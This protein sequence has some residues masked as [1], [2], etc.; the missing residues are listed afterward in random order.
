MVYH[1]NL[2]IYSNLIY[3]IYFCY[4]S[5]KIIKFLV[6]LSHPNTILSFFIVILHLGEIISSKEA[7]ILLVIISLINF[8]FLGVYGKA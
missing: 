4:C 7:V 2:K 6:A 8:L 5:L 1:L 3:S